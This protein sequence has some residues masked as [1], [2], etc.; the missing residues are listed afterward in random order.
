MEQADFATILWRAGIVY[1]DPSYMSLVKGLTGG[2]DG[3][4]RLTFVDE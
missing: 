1:R 4:I 2:G 3:R